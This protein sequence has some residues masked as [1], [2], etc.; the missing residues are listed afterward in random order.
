MFRRWGATEIQIFAMESGRWVWTRNKF[1][2]ELFEAEL[3]LVQ[4][5][6]REWLRATTDTGTPPS[7]IS[8][9]P[10]EFLLSPAVGML[11]LFKTL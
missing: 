3:P 1:G 4:Q 6:Y 9:F 11:H 8:E 7:R 10:K 5:K 2:Y